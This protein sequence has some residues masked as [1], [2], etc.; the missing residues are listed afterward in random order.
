MSKIFQTQQKMVGRADTRK[1]EYGL[2]LGRKMG[3][4][5]LILLMGL[6]GF[7]AMLAVSLIFVLSSVMDR[8]TNS[9]EDKASIE[10]VAVDT[11]GVE[12]N[13][14]YMMSQARKVLMRVRE[15][16]V[17]R[18]AEI[19][20]KEQVENL[21]AP[22]IGQTQIDLD[23]LP[24]P[25]LISVDLK[26]HDQDALN[27]LEAEIR[28]I[29]PLARLDRHEQWLDE[30]VGFI[31]SISAAS[32]VVGGLVGFIIFVT[33]ASA[34]KSRMAV[35][36]RELMLLHHMGASDSYISRQFERF[37]FYISLKGASI[38]IA[39]LLLVFGVMALFS[40]GGMSGLVPEFSLSPFQMF[41]LTIVPILIVM[42]ACITA[43]VTTMRNL[44]RMP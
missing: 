31:S 29:D 33:M 7:L 4:D 44:E 14:E 43:R 24:M 22:W 34:I 13:R 42:M 27:V 1:R 9:L 26:S 19:V 8:W 40:D 35:F 30:V 28:E 15:S 10:I 32:Y 12:K 16:D 39:C 21:L 3:N 41:V 6:M 17:V 38:S 36:D 20:D 18:N 5:F 23:I 37:A 25:I 2:P 11:K